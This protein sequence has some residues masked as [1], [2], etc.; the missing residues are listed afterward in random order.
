MP[1][2][3]LV[4]AVVALVLSVVAIMR[5]GGVHGARSKTADLLDQLEKIVRGQQEKEK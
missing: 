4:I 2:V 1:T 5:T 3:T